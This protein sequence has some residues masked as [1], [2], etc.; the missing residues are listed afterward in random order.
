MPLVRKSDTERGQRLRAFLQRPGVQGA[1]A[2][3]I[4]AWTGL[5][6]TEFALGRGA[7]GTLVGVLS[8]LIAT[9]FALELVLRAFAAHTRKRFLREYWPDLV[10]V[11]S[12]VPGSR[13]P[14]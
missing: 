5:T 6:V 9:V 14:G 2:A 1:V 7:A 13:S 4:L 8:Q 11:A 10:A 3:L 12:A